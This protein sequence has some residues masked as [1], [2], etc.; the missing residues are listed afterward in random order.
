MLGATN[1]ADS[2]PGTIRG[3]LCIDV[4]RNICHGSDSVESANK[5]IALW[6]KPEELNNYKHHSEA[7][8]YENVLEEDTSATE[9]TEGFTP[10]S[11]EYN[12]LVTYD[13][14]PS[15]GK[16]FPATQSLKIVPKGHHDDPPVIGTGKPALFVFFAKY[17]KYEAFPAVEA[18]SAYAAEFGI[19]TAGVVLDNKEKDVARFI[20]KKPCKSDFALYFDKGWLF[21]KEFQREILGMDTFPMPS[22]CL[23]NGDG[24]IAYFQALSGMSGTMTFATS[25]FDYQIRQF[26]A[27]KPFGKHGESGVEKEDDTV[28]G[29]VEE[30]DVFAKQEVADAIW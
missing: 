2:A 24:T 10:Y 4:G 21:K 11:G 5:E 25:Q 7:F 6:F 17:L 13:D 1:P 20:E 27:G 29:P 26:I 19:Q 18:A 12:E 16:K 14:H 8:V 23:V 9:A 30:A 3:D 15:W 22:L 28:E